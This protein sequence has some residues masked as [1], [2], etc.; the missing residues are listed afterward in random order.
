MG[1]RPFNC[2]CNAK[3]LA[4]FGLDYGLPDQLRNQFSTPDLELRVDIYATRRWVLVVRDIV[5]LY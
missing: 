2:A 5:G 1:P 3:V 4:V